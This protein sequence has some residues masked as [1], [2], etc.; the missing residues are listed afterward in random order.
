MAHPFHR[1]LDRPAQSSV[2]VLNLGSA[3]EKDLADG[4][5]PGKNVVTLRLVDRDTAR[6][7]A[8]YPCARPASRV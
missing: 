8:G 2:R 7:I 1:E 5:E 6:A 3:K 4:S